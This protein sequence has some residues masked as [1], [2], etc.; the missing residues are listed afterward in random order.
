MRRIVIAVI[1]AALC[2]TANAQSDDE[3]LDKLRGLYDAP[4]TR[5]LVS[6]TCDVQ[7]DWNNH[8]VQTIGTVPPAALPT[9]RRLQTAHHRV[10]VDRSS[11]TISQGPR[12][13]DISELPH[14]TDLENALQAMITSGLN[15]WIPFATN[16][17]LPVRPTTFTI[18]HLDSGA[19]MVMNGPG[20]SATL[21]LRPD[22]R[23]VDVLSERPQSLHFSTEF[24]NGPNGY[25][26]QSVKTGSGAADDG[27]WTASFVYQ[28]QSIDGFQIPGAV[29]VT[30]Q[31]TGEKWAYSLTDCKTMTGVTL[32]VL[33]PKN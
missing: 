17:I 28:Y 23:I 31:A 8:F 13:E 26:L 32:K 7:F 12:P 4:F 30:Q 22:M 16:V 9:L 25:L 5:N 15:A 29:S 6:F 14:A 11:A 10:F 20:V 2:L 24:A 3:A 1:L 21:L 18:Q 33:P 27:T 19:K